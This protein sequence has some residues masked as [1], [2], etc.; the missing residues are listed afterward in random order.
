MFW[1]LVAE[2]MVPL[3]ICHEY[4]VAPAGP[5]AVLPVEFA[6]TCAGV[7]VMA[8]VAGLAL[9]VTL[10]LFEAE[11]PAPLVTVRLSS[12]G[13]EAPAV[14]VMVWMLVAEVIAPLMIDQA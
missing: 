4:V 5:L 9:M 10:T 6:Q 1:M 8:G 12:T 3:V 2:V 13:P 7:G 14:Y 11:Q